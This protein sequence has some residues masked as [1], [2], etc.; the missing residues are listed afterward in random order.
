MDPR[1]AEFR[2][3]GLCAAPF[4][5]FDAEGG[6]HLGGIAAQVD[7][8]VKGG[9]V[10]AFVNGTTGESL[11]LTHEE[12]KT[13]LER[14]VADAGERLAVIA[15]VGAQSLADTC[16][17]AAHAERVGAKA[18][19]FMPPTFFRPATLDALVD[20]RS[21]PPRD[22][23]KDDDEIDG[24][25]HGAWRH[26]LGCGGELRRDRICVARLLE[27]SGFAASPRAPPRSRHTTTTSRA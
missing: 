6:L 9:V 23:K 22:G 19:G 24:C 12:R 10:A 11:S 1:V 27:R 8:L 16:D 20:V 4:A 18:Y 7:E 15:H 17:L 5:S 14:W 3:V 2:V 25:S 21:P 26:G 13:V